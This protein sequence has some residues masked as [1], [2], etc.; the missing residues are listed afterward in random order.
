MLQSLHVKNFA[1]IDELEV[2]FKDKL[3]ILSG[4]TGSGKSIIIGSINV[5]L[6][7]KVS[8]EMVRRNAEYALVELV[9]Y[10]DTKNIS[11]KLKELELPE[12]DGMICI[13]RRI[14]ANGR[15][16]TKVNGE[17]ASSGAVKELAGVLIDIHGQYEHQSLLYKKKHLDILDRYAKDDIDGYK[18]QLKEAYRTYVECSEKLDASRTDEEKRLREISLL[19][20][21]INE[22][23]NAH[24]INGEEEELDALYRKLANAQQISEAVSVAHECTGDSEEC[25]AN[26]IGKAIR[27]LQKAASYDKCINDMYE[28]L[29]EVEGL[30]NDFNREISDYIDELQNNEEEMTTTGSRLD[31]IRRLEAKYGRTVEDVLNYLAEAS[32]KLEQYT[33]YEDFIARL[34]KKRNEAE[35]KVNKLCTAITEIR[36]NE[37]LMLKE[38][39]FNALKELNFLDVR[40]DI[41]FEQCPEPGSNGWDDVEFMISTNPGEAIQPLAKVASGGELSRVM[42]AIKSVLA[43]KDETDTLIFD[44]IDAGISGRTAQKVS[45]RLSAIA[46]S[47]QVLCITHLP[48]IA[49]M[50]DNHFLI[51]KVTDGINTTTRIRALND[52][53]R[54]DEVARLL[55]G[56]RITES[57]LGNAREM[58][59][60]ANLTKGKS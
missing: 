48:Q 22:I 35:T 50:A 30:L 23:T 59:E 8:K 10:C 2:D 27:A 6:G 26:G 1:I 31:E 54:I 32:V 34:E 29:S 45:E 49:S 41:H 18:T 24:L 11:D 12:E 42:L 43:D 51:E 38:K 53:E 33:N 21:E 46:Y 13:A 39:I 7:G 58:I 17:N 52:V 47:H 55:G 28:E 56:A 19:E 20:F 9:F 14:M 5:A 4:E 37:A 16:I 44:E 57:V 25:A 60:L 15:S 3:N 36:K 40:F